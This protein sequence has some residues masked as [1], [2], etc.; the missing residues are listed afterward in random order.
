MHIV[1]IFFLYTSHLKTV[2][3]LEKYNV[4]QFAISNRVCQRGSLSHYLFYVY[5]DDPSKK[6]NCVNT[7]CILGSSLIIHL[8]C[9]AFSSVGVSM[10]LC[11][12]SEYRIE[13]DIKNA[14]M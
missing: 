7:G 13:R 14:I 6:L 1:R 10:L 2:H 3:T 5:M 11:V 9:A 8:M 4:Q 12:F